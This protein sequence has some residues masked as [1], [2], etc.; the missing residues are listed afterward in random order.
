VR[1]GEQDFGN[2]MIDAL[3]ARL[4]VMPSSDP[5]ARAAILA[6]VRGRRQSP[7]R[8]AAIGAWQQWAPQ[9]AV[10]AA[11]VAFVGVG[12]GA[13]VISEP[14][15]GETVA[16]TSTPTI[17]VMQ[18][19][20]DLAGT[21]AVPTTF[22]LKANGANRVSLIGDFNGWDRSVTAMS[23]PS[24][25]GVWEITVPLPPGRHTYAF[26]VNDSL[27]TL[28]PR[29][30]QEKDPDFGTPSSVILVTEKR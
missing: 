2:E 7:W 24:K 25:N 8:A 19:S 12:Y 16:T 29:M 1:D 28:D 23:D 21:R 4:K 22:I 17:P 27:W 26:L 5:R 14:A 18:V 15:P 11:I 3:V 30:P 13:R 6:R 10:A 20:N 9:L